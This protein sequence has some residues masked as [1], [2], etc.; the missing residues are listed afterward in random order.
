MNARTL[1]AASASAERE[2]AAAPAAKPSPA[3]KSPSAK[4]IDSGA[5]PLE[6]KPSDAATSSR[7][8]TFDFTEPPAPEATAPE[9]TRPVSLWA[10]IARTFHGADRHM[11]QHPPSHDRYADQ[12]QS[13]CPQ[14]PD[15]LADAAMAREMF[16]L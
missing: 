11:P 15:F 10:R 7:Q 13:A 3:N 14:R 2:T 1:L 5:H 16:R 6:T 4:I 12:E 9:F 8:T